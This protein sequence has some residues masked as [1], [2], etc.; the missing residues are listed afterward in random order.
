MMLP[1]GAEVARQAWSNTLLGLLSTIP[2]LMGKLSLI[3]SREQY[4][5]NGG[6]DDSTQGA[7]CEKRSRNG[8][9]GAHFQTMVAIQMRGEKGP[10]L[11][12]GTE[13][14]TV[15]GDQQDAAQ[16]GQRRGWAGS[17]VAGGG[18]ILHLDMSESF[19][20]DDF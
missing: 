5:L 10:E 8:Q 6:F 12:G 1:A 13:A 7:L 20:Q 3:C 16:D 4:D 17:G 18:D 11:T 15:N 19:E 2:Q 14:G 9:A